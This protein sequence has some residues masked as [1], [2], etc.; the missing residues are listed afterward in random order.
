[1]QACTVCKRVDA[2]GSTHVVPNLASCL[3]LGGLAQ[4]LDVI[5]F[6][7]SVEGVHEDAQAP[8]W[9]SFFVIQL[10]EDPILRFCLH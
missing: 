1:M 10:C 6:A 2:G 9:R 5:D 3:I 4:E 8:A 7:I